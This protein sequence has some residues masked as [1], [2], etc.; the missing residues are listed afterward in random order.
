MLWNLLYR[1]VFVV[2]VVVSDLMLFILALV[3]NKIIIIIIYSS[4]SL[5]L[6][7]VS[8]GLEFTSTLR[9]E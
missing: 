4:R 3:A 8:S 5:K 9:R 6:N 7:S 2:Y 1:F